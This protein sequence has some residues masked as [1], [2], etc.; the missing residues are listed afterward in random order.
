MER[1][2]K[3]RAELTPI[4]KENGEK[5]FMTKRE[6]GKIPRKKIIRRKEKLGSTITETLPS[7]LARGK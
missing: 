2:P 1:K 3:T 6:N 7:I 4:I 5:K